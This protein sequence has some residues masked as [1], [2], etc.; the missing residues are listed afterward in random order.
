M[1]NLHQLVPSSN[2]DKDALIGLGLDLTSALVPF[3]GS[4]IADVSRG[5]LDRQAAAQQHEFNVAVVDAFTELAQSIEGLTAEA[6]LG[7]NEFLSALTKASRYASESDSHSK[8]RRLAWLAAQSGPWSD[9]S[10]Q[11]RTYFLARAADYSDI[12]VFLLKYFRDPI[13]WQTEHSS[14]W[15]LD[16]YRIADLSPFAIIDHPA[17][18][19]LHYFR[20]GNRV[21]SILDNDYPGADDFEIHE[22]EPEASSAESLASLPGTE[23]RAPSWD[24]AIAILGG[25]AVVSVDS[26]L[27]ESAFAGVGGWQE[28]IASAVTDLSNDGM[29]R[30]SMGTKI[31]YLEALAK[32]TT[33]FGDEFLDYLAEPES[34][35][36]LFED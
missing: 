15:S 22:R 35:P 28:L 29:V 5:M 19:R 27:G 20:V 36:P 9:V 16:E 17:G 13:A 6:I 18:G 8:R 2:P 3:A 25:K 14:H 31:P 23:E 11:K 32:Q 12:H 1:A 21:F 4:F 10:K 24:E 34:Y 7:S 30:V 33:P 26:I